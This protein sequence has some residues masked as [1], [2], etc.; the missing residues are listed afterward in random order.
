[1]PFPVALAAPAPQLSCPGGLPP[2][3]GYPKMPPLK[4]PS[5]ELPSPTENGRPLRQNSFPSKPPPVDRA[6]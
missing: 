6:F 3:S 1:M 5:A 2:T 4:L